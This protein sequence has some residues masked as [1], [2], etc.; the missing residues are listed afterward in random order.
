MEG[1]RCSETR[2]FLYKSAWL[3][4]S[5][6]RM[7]LRNSSPPVSILWMSEKCAALPF[8]CWLQK[9]VRRCTDCAGRVSLGGF[10]FETMW[11]RKVKLGI[12]NHT[13]FRRRLWLWN[14]SYPAQFQEKFRNTHMLLLVIMMVTQWKVSTWNRHV[15]QTVTWYRPL[16]NTDIVTWYRPLR[17]TDIVTWSRHCSTTDTEKPSVL[18]NSFWEK[19]GFSRYSFFLL[20]VLT[21]PPPLPISVLHTVLTHFLR[22]ELRVPG[23]NQWKLYILLAICPLVITLSVNFVKTK[24]ALL[25]ILDD[26]YRLIWKVSMVT[27]VT[28][29][30]IIIHAWGAPRKVPVMVVLL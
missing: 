16:R 18:W 24:G 9:L 12:S 1:R 26:D 28:K 4:T 7:F 20:S 10:E 22:T 17:D 27:L 30:V 15:T 19:E 29:V 25:S 14:D 5:Q 13:N 8:V 23:H 11:G 2:V 6:N 21:C 3:R